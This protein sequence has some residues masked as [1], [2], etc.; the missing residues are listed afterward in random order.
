MKL[1]AGFVIRDLPSA[2]AGGNN[3]H[4]DFNRASAHILLKTAEGETVFEETSPLSAWIWGYGMPGTERNALTHKT[5][6]TPK[7]EQQYALTLKITPLAGS[8]AVKPAALRISGG[9]RKVPEPPRNTN[10]EPK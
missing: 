3:A 10:K 1:N 7:P 9:G 8:K 2:P 4:N 6:F 5:H